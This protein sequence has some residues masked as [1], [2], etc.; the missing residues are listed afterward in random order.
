MRHQDGNSSNSSINEDELWTDSPWPPRNA[1]CFDLLNNFM[2]RCNDVL[3]LVETTRHF[4]LLADAAEI[5]GAG[6]MSLDALVK[7]IHS[8]YTHSMREFFNVVGNVLSIDGTQNFER[9]FFKF[10]TVVKALEKRLSEILRLSYNQCPTVDAQLRLLEVFEGVSSRELVQVHL[11]D[12]D[13]LLI[14]AFSVELN[15]VRQMFEENQH[16][17]PSHANM[18]RIVSKLMWTH[19][20]IQRIQHPMEKMKRVSPHSL[21]GDSGWQMRD[22]Y[23]DVHRMLEDFKKGLM[24]EWR[25]NITAE[26]TLRL[27]QPLLIA[28]EFDEDVEARPQVIHVNLDSQLLRILREISYLSQEPF[29][30]QLPSTAKELVRNTNAFELRVTAT[31]LETI[32][33]KYNTI[34]RTITEFE[35][36]LFERKLSKIDT[37]FEQGLQ[38]YAWKMKE[39]ADFIEQA[40]A[41]V[42]LDVHQNLDTVQTNCHEIAEITISWSAGTLDVFSGRAMDASYSMEELLDMQKTLTEDHEALVLPSGNKI[43]GLVQVSFEA[44]QISQASP[45]WVDYIDYIDAIVLDGLKHATLASLKSMLNNLVQANMDEDNIIMPILTIRL[46][47]ID[48]RVAF[49]PP[50]DQ[51][52]SVIS[53][54]ELVQKWLD[55]YLARGKLVKMLGPKGTYQD[56]ISAD[57][58][59]KQLL[60]DISSMVDD[61]SE[62]C[63]KLIEIFGDYAFLWLQDVNMTFEE[64]LRG[65]L[66]PNPLRSPNRTMAGNIRQMA[67]ERSRSR[68]SSRASSTSSINSAGLMGTAERTFLTPK[69]LTEDA[70][71][72]IPSL[73]EFDSE[74]EIYRTAR[75]EIQSLEDFHN[76]GWLRVDLQPIKQVLTTYASKWMWTYTKYLSDQVSHMLGNLDL[77]LK[78]IEPEIE[79]I[80]GEERDTASFMKMMRL[81]N[82]VSAQQSEMDGKFT[83]MH[84]TVL[85][86][87]KYGQK[88]PDRTQQLFNA[89][90]GR[91]NNLKTKV[92]LAKQRLGPRIQEE[93]VRITQDLEAFGN[94][95]QALYQELENSDVYQRDCIIGDAWVII[96]NF[97]KRLTVLENE[98]QDLIE[99][100]ELLETS[101]VNFAILPQCRHEL[102]NL[103]QVWETVRVIDEQQAEWKRHRWQK[104]NTKFLREETNKQLDIVRALPED[105]FTW[106]VY[107]GLHESITTVQTCLPLIDDLSN[108]AMRTRHWKQLVRVTGGALTIDNDTLKR[109][110]LGELLSLGLQ[111]HVD[112]VRV[113]VQKA[114]KDLSIEQSLKTYDEIWLSKIFETRL[115]T[116]SRMEQQFSSQDAHSES[117]SEGGQS[118]QHVAIPSRS[119]ARTTSRISNQ[120]SHSKNKRSS[121]ASLP[122]SLL[123]LGEVIAN[124]YGTLSLLTATDPIFQELE[125]HQVSL[126]AMQA[127]SAAG[128]FLDDVLKWQK[129]LQTIEAV[130]TTW[131]E[132]QEK[133]VELEEV[134]SGADVRTSLSH[135]ANRFAVVNKDFRLLM[136]ATEKNPNVLQCCSRKNILSILEHM[137]HSLESCRRSLLNHLERRR[138]IFPR[139]YFLSMEDVL[140]LVCNG[141][142]LKQVNLFISK[143]FEN[144]GSLVYEEVEDNEKYSFMITGVLSTLGERL[145]FLQ[146]VTCEGQ[147]ETW[148]TSFILGLKNA[149]QF[150]MATAMGVEKPKP[151]TRTIRSA[152][153]RKVAVP[154][155]ASS[156][157]SKGKGWESLRKRFGIMQTVQE[158]KEVGSRTSSRAAKRDT[159]EPMSRASSVADQLLTENDRG[160]QQ[161]SWT[162]DHVTEIVYLAT[163]VQMTEK[164]ESALKELEG[165]TKDSLQSALQKVNQSIQ[166]TT[167]LLKGLEG[168]RE[169]KGRNEVSEPGR[170]MKEAEKEELSESASVAGA[171]S[172]YAASMAG[173]SRK[174]STLDVGGG[175]TARTPILE[176]EG[177]TKG[178]EQSSLMEPQTLEPVDTMNILAAPPITTY[179]KKEEAKEEAPQGDTADMKLMLFPSQIQKLTS[180]LALLAHVRDF[181]ERMIEADDTAALSG[182]EW[183]SHLR[184][185]FSKDNRAVNVKTLDSQ[186]D[187][188]YE[189]VGSSPRE[190]IT[191]L[192]ER[193]FVSLTQTVK[194]HMGAMCVGPMDSGKF[195]LVHELAR[196]LGYPLFKF[197]CTSNMDY[198]Q[199][200]DIFRGMASTGCWVCFNNISNLTPAVLSV[201]A[202]LI[203]AVMG[204]LR[205]GK[206]AVHLQSDDI[207]LNPAGACFALTDSAVQVQPGNPEK[208]LLYSSS[209]AAIPDYIMVQFRTISVLQPDLQ[210][211][212]EVMLSSQG[213]VSARVLAKKTMTLYELCRRLMGTN[214]FITEN[215]TLGSDVNHGRG[216]WSMKTLKG[217]VSEAG[218]Y[219]EKS[220][221]QEKEDQ[222]DK[223][224]QET[225]EKAEEVFSESK[226]LLEEKSLV[227][228]I[229]DTFL[230][231]MKGRDASVFGTLVVDTWPNVEVPMVFGGE[232]DMLPKPPQSRN[233]SGKG[234]SSRAKTAKSQDSVRSLKGF[235]S[236]E[237]KLLNSINLNTP[238][239]TMAHSAQRF[240]PVTD[241]NAPNQVLEDMHDAIAVATG[242]LGLLPGVAFQSRVAQLSQLNAAHQAVFVVGPPGCGKSECIKTF[243]VA[244]RERGKTISVHTLFTKAV[245]SEELMG[246]WDP[247]TKEWKDGL[248]A[249]L[250]RKLCIQ[251]PSMNYD[252]N[253]KPTMKIVQLDGEADVGQMELLA[254]FLNNDGSVVLGNNERMII[255]DTTRFFWELETVGHMS[256]ALLAN[257]AILH[258]SNLDVGWKLLLVQWLERRPEADKELL[259]GFCDVY[260][261]KTVDYLT[262]CCQPHILGGVK[263]TGPQYKRVIPHSIENMINTFCTLLEAL[264]HSNPDLSDLEYERYFNFAIIWAFAG[265][266]EVEHRESFSH[267][268]K[269]EFNQYIEYPAEG[270]VFDY[271]VDSESHEFTRWCDS[272][273]NYSGDPH[274]GISSEAFVH[275]VPIEQLMYLLG[276]LSDYGKP[277]V[278][279]GENGCGK[280]AIINER[281]R[282]VCSGEV[283][284]VLSL[285]VQANRFTNAR[286]L[287]DRLDGRLEW[288][289]GRTYVPKGN[290]RLLC[291]VDDINLSQVDK[292]GHQ[293]AIELV[294][295][296]IDDGG[297]YNQDTHAWRYVKNVTYVSTINP[298][299]TAN[300]PAI[301]QRFLRHF[302][303]FGC[304]YPTSSDLQTIFSTLL[305]THFITP[306]TSSSANLAGGHHGHDEKAQNTQKEEE[307][308]MRR[309]LSLIV[310]VNVDLQDRLRS[311]FLPTAQRCHYIFTVRDLSTIFKNLCLSLQ[312]GC[313]KKNVLLLWQHETF[314]VYGHRMVLDVDFRRFKQ[315]F[316]TAVKKE[317]TADEYIQLL[318]KTRRPLFSNLIEQDSGV[319][320]AGMIDMRHS[321]QVSEEDARTDLYKPVYIDTEAKAL[322]ERGVEEYNKIHP[323]IKLA[324]YKSVVEQVCRIARTIASPHESAHL[325]LN[326]EGCPGRC[327]VIV[328]LAAHLCGYTVHQINPSSM[329]ATSEYKMDQFKADLVQGYTRAGSKVN[330]SSPGEKILLLLHEEELLEEDFL[331]YLI[332]FIIGGSISHLFTYEEQTTIINSIRTEVTQAGLTYTRDT[333]WNFFL[334]TVRNNFRICLISSDSGKMFQRRCREYPAFTKNVNFIW[335]PHWSKLQLVDHALYHLKDVTW[336]TDVQ[337][338]NIAHMLASMHL[339]LRQ[340]DGQ[341]KDSGEYRHITN[342]TY[343]KF[344][345]RYIS[346]ASTKHKEV[347]EVHEAVT[348]SL[349]Q[350]RRENEV[351]MKLRKQ[352]EHEMIVLEERKAGTIKILS[353]IGQDTAITEQQ[354]K[355]VK[356]QL[357]KISKLKKLL[358][359]YQVA[360]E[361]A[362]YKAIAIVADTKKVVQSMNAEKLAELRGMNK[363]IIDIEDLMTAVIMILKTPSADLTWQKGAKRQMANLERFIEELTSFDDNQL[364]ESTLNLVEPYLKKPSFDPDTLEKKTGNSACGSLC[365]WVRGVVRYHR[366]MISKVKP[367]HQK[368]EE[369]TQAVDDAEHKMATLENKRKGLDVRL[370]DLAKGFEEAT[371]DKN[372][373][374]E[375]T[376]RMKKMLETAAQL[377]RTLKGERKRC[378]QIFDSYERRILSVPGGC[379]MS[380]ALATYLGPYHHNFRRMMLTVHWPNCLRERGIPLVIDSIDGLKGR[381]IDWSIDFL[382][383]AG[384]ASTVYDIDYTSALMGQTDIEDQP[385]TDRSVKTNIDEGDK[386]ETK[387]EE[388]SE[389]QKEKEES[390]EEKKDEEKEVTEKEENNVEEKEKDDSDGKKEEESEA[391][392]EETEEK[393]EK[394]EEETTQPGEKTS[395]NSGGS[396][397]EGLERIQ[398]EGDEDNASQVTSSSAPLLTSTQYNKYVVSL[399]K[400]LVGERTLNDWLRKDFGPRQIENAAILCSSWQR[401]PMLID[402]NGDGSVWL[403]RLNNLMNKKKLV[404]LDMDTRIITKTLIK[405]DP[406]VIMTLEKAIMRGKPV[407]LSNCEEHIDNIITPLMH[408]RNTANENDKD[409][410]PRMIRFC[411]RR[412]LCH[413]DFRFYLSAPLAKPKF[414][415]EI[416]SGTT[417]INFGVSHDTLTEDLLTRAFARMRPKLFKERR[418][419]LKNMQLQRDTLLRLSEI[420]KDRILTQQEA[421]LGSAKALKFIT[422]ITNAKMEL[423]N[424][425]T[426]T[427]SLLTDLDDLKDELFPLARRAAMLYA[428]LRSLQSIHN[429][430]QFTMRYFVD[431]FDEAVGGEVPQEFWDED[432]DGGFEDS[433]DQSSVDLEKKRRTGSTSSHASKD[434]ATAGAQTTEKQSKS[435]KDKTEGE[436]EADF[437]GDSHVQSQQQAT[438]EGDESASTAAAQKL[439]AGSESEDLP[440]LEIPET[441]TLPSEGVEYD[442]LSANQIKKIMDGL[443]GL[444]YRRVRESLY[445]E[446]C[447]L[448]TTL[449]TLNIQAEGMENFSNEEMSLLLQ[450]NP[451][452]GMQLTL[453]D[454]DCKDS[455]PDWMPQEKWED[456]M[457]LS[458]L[459]GPLDSLC[460]NM[461]QNSDGWQAWYRSPHPEKEALPPLTPVEGEASIENRPGSGG[462]K[463]SRGSG[464]KSPDLGPLSDFHQLLLLRMLRPDRL[465]IA[466]VRYVNKHLTINLPNQSEFN[467]HEVLKDA[468]RHLGVLL[469]L[470][471]SVING[472]RNPSSRLSLTHPPVEVLLQLAELVGAKVEHVRVG[473]GCEIQVEEAIDSAEK[474]DGWVIIE[475]LHLSPKGFFNELKKHLVRM[476]R[477]RNN[478]KEENKSESKFCVWVTSEP[479]EQIPDFLLRNLH[480]LAWN[481]MT[482]HK[483][484]TPPHKADDDAGGRQFTLTYKSPHT[485][486]H[487]AIVSTLK[488][489]DS[490]IMGKVASEPQLIRTM[491]FG[492]AVVQ[493]MLVARQLFG[494]QGLNQWYPFNSVQIEQSIE[495]LSGQ[496]LKG[497]E[498]AEPKLDE[499]TNLFTELVYKNC[500]YTESDKTYVEAVIRQVLTNVYQDTSGQ[501]ILG[502]VSI[503]TPPANVEPIGFGKWFADNVDDDFTIPALQLH[504]SVEREVNEANSLVFIENL[505]HMF[506]TQN[507]EA[508]DVARSTKH[509]INIMKLRSSLDLC[510]EEL[511]NLLELGSVPEILSNDFDFPYHRPSLISLATNSSTQMPETIG[512]CLL[513]ECLWLNSSL[514]HIRQ[515]IAD[516]QTSLLGG[517]EALAWVLLPTVYSLQE[518]QV[519][520]SWVHPNCQPCTH[521][522]LSWLDHTKKC[523]EQLHNWVKHGMVPTFKENSLGENPVIAHGSLASVWLGGLVNPLALLT[524]YLQEKA[525][526]S[527]CSM[528][529]ISYECVVMDE[530][531]IKDYDIDEGGLFIT[532]I[533]LQGASWSYDSDSLTD[534]KSALF[535]IPCIY[536]RPKTKNELASKDKSTIYPCPV[537]MNKSRQ[538]LTTTLDLNCTSPVD[539]WRLS[540]VALVLDPGLPEDGVKK[541]RSYLMLTRAPQMMTME[542]ES[543]L[544]SEEEEEYIRIGDETTTDVDQSEQSTQLSYRPMTPKAPPLPAGLGLRKEAVMVE[545]EEE[546]LESGGQRSEEKL[547]AR[548]AESTPKKSEK[549]SPKATPKGSVKSLGSRQGSGLGS[550][551]EQADNKS[552][553]PSRGSNAGNRTPGSKSGSRQQSH[554]TSQE[555]EVAEQSS[556]PRSEHEDPVTQMEI[557][558]E[559]TY[560]DPNEVKSQRSDKDSMK[561]NA[562]DEQPL[563]KAPS[564]ESI[565]KSDKLS[566]APSKE[567]VN[568]S[569]KLS[570]AASKESVNKSDKLSKGASRESV[571]KVGTMSK[572]ASKESVNKVGTMSKGA[573][574]ESVNKTAGQT[575]AGQRSKPGSRRPSGGSQRSQASPA[576][577]GQGQRR[578]SQGSR[579]STDQ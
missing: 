42:C 451:G 6:S 362:V 539:Q 165:G 115:H 160:D 556:R 239:V 114:V 254:A 337:R 495:A 219:M 456:I 157:M 472:T 102:N 55:G 46:E 367:L 106:D 80:T 249:S 199:L 390:E 382:K 24:L 30:I 130:L 318:V 292:Y 395:T 96:D 563:T 120:S 99:L 134:F 531:N 251:P 245:E 476:A 111:T 389:K 121:I 218:A 553:A 442:N 573:S 40:M 414:N 5:G 129:K 386:E 183:R 542:E 368:V 378:E 341:E 188:G 131:L 394:L 525:I 41:L 258:M 38:Q 10:R 204:A 66:S 475:D 69:N 513:Q 547:S 3:E 284:E 12:K 94:R 376:V 370:D 490:G 169:N 125:H 361:R 430:Y 326:A 429:E 238:V 407:L 469:L 185:Y 211:A 74:I 559:T 359:E 266:L 192:T 567:S 398:E 275:T 73:D 44:V 227:L 242:E 575:E 253:S 509:N 264:V 35:K 473:E 243:A 353:Q 347:N 221:E 422:D 93:S 206:A 83:A 372:E 33:S 419:A 388:S 85:L 279:V 232:E 222:V 158:K 22:L 107:M 78:R 190:V 21:E 75:D 578:Q 71:T 86:L 255:P 189:Y 316:S 268:W 493:G 200:H 229:R 198:M 328:K 113:I 191:P 512:Y 186:F 217:L 59:V 396:G 566:K 400:L 517:P 257:V 434:S 273:T 478:N 374:D 480:K 371:I 194:A 269:E 313:S 286:L 346:L 139:F 91:W 516:L 177:S 307:D 468:K 119:Q 426:E 187:Y 494:T 63:K 330:S 492:V 450:G 410:E 537:Y 329:G 373:Q 208:L 224:D 354:I 82:E 349:N 248:F 486:L 97:A 61:N 397:R 25:E 369:T 141:Y 443:T 332:E 527:K 550:P 283:A 1:P 545:E 344:V 452:L 339:V 463:H 260:I 424:Q 154:A 327:T 17:P 447:L 420:V 90:P 252:F 519:P 440:P 319:V 487:T 259:S 499:I 331:V 101:V 543:E 220:S 481:H 43:H 413:Q 470:P 498:D 116:R 37:L 65:K 196:C 467:I 464:S 562:E 549:N 231:R 560:P 27:K 297:F 272:M 72:S 54:Q 92:S 335:L 345:E 178:D 311:M 228:A 502:G 98:A 401:P 557:E 133:W 406:H 184:F 2:E 152:G 570:K 445:E 363:P 524:S 530:I 340:Q 156:S 365:K 314:W 58:E 14:K 203:S 145:D 173:A 482:I 163:R 546:D 197:N 453:E 137:N 15:N 104:M 510:L 29:N 300:V 534:A 110:T 541:S 477:A 256:P 418:L 377:R 117:Q 310:Q 32:V 412:V 535:S 277:V 52:S 293:T 474:N 508:G 57:E 333:A 515:Q 366:M 521:S 384:G 274:S 261:Q 13:A 140:H 358:P 250:L 416:A 48:N 342:T 136:R 433:D 142:D 174:G 379:A 336:M 11:R 364:A 338:E 205:A 87:K 460:I 439:I 167:V 564:K 159:K 81:F 555:L 105:I 454:F 571:N 520:V 449:L 471:P 62:E 195:E 4:R 465:P 18:P 301:S 9:A 84:R 352:Q 322:M 270:T 425:L 504:N 399:V 448:F 462:S 528:D 548:T 500:V 265:T 417:L 123:N 168:E 212:L 287:Y 103:K 446:D 213:F 479:C 225:A 437:E 280:T 135:D 60:E 171:R 7:E 505:D 132:V 153:S 529:D 432:E 51:S 348:S 375:K 215:I 436:Y 77:F 532:E 485:Y 67:S 214:V 68:S 455:P 497:T 511:P 150:Q 19:G 299:T 20:L 28:E 118:L 182:F 166:A 241:P 127:N 45:A 64:F 244:E 288:K 309:L 325:V 202:Q 391:K 151:R 143:V 576:N 514:C 23:N 294:R 8:K 161:K 306:E 408:H 522:L 496:L 392:G 312:P 427:Q 435:E 321:S 574:K 411:G 558:D 403:G 506:E 234:T 431:L 276:T 210:L 262:E 31:R 201:Y 209:T 459:P 289:H 409:E 579:K 295:E 552:P 172:S 315:A 383:T 523:H 240:Q 263:R 155:R 304:P 179:N 577:Q 350:I 122:A 88:L 569:D 230:P 404:S 357:D 568:K 334:Q 176:E 36:P 423:A 415:P 247:K 381:V 47:L 488:Q 267:W 387:D 223:L 50:L 53:V 144:V 282:T 305:H 128:S 298:C 533:N 124:D 402:P 76:V 89:A 526:V 148:L 237:F 544:A 484:V 138:Q 170:S 291:L 444:V 49:R 421:M 149:L 458:V 405:T 428:I 126:Q 466:L 501:L 324:L 79:S 233:S 565:S 207:Q 351:A 385:V 503:P 572:G 343:E 246:Y 146:P 551:R 162:L 438:T 216:G 226:L 108:P 554:R 317:F 296:H 193:V 491:A 540:R 109:M 461:A 538:V 380:A 507:M 56:Y 281:I 95:V 355:V 320:T 100:Q 302:A 236:Y 175:E 16:H 147:I 360:H 323:R 112:D 489:V 536:L 457:A 26:L 561:D 441:T 180:L 235:C 393:Q 70:D 303:V 518:E 285:T 278:L 271:Y 308:A 39:S 181:L 164:I 290:K 34:M 356:A 483:E